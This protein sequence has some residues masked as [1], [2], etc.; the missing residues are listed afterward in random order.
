[1]LALSD[2]AFET[3]REAGGSLSLEEAATWMCAID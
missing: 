3:G 2:A 1:V